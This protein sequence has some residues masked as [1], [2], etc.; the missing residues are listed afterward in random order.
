[1]IPFQPTEED[2]LILKLENKV[3]ELQKML[4]QEERKSFY[5]LL[6]MIILAVFLVVGVLL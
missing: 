1:M 6:L 2:R 4:E 3:F 5:F